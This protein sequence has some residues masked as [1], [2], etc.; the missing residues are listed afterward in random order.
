MASNQTI[1]V[2]NANA[3]VPEAAATVCWICGAANAN[4]GE[5][6]IKKSDLRDVLGK[7]SQAAPFYFHKPALEGKAVGSL[8]HDILKSAAPMCAYCNNTRTQPHDLA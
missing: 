5:H 1:A 4:S 7:P 2:S 3:V 8:K 6:M